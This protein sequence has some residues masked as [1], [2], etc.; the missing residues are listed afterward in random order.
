MVKV[1]I[2]ESLLEPVFLLDKDGLI[3]YA[4]PVACNLLQL[5]EKRIIGKKRFSDF[6]PQYLNGDMAEFLSGVK[7]PTPYKE[8]EFARE[9]EIGRVQ[10]S[11]QKLGDQFLVYTR[12]VTLENR[13]QSKYQKQLEE[14]QC[15]IEEL[16]KAQ[17]ELQKINET[18]EQRVVERTQ[19]LKSLNETMSA[20]LDSLDQGFLIFTEEGDCLPVYSKACEDIFGV[21]PSGQKIWD[22]FRISRD[23]QGK[24]LDWLRVLF[25]NALPFGDLAILGPQNLT[26]LNSRHISLKYFPIWLESRELKSVVVMATDISP[27][28]AAKHE[29]E[30]QKARAQCVLTLIHHPS[31][32]QR[33]SKEANQLIVNLEEELKAPHLNMESAFRTLHTIKGGASSFAF[34]PLVESCH[35]GEEILDSQRQT[36][37]L[38]MQEIR[39]SLEEVRKE[40]ASFDELLY[41]L[42]KNRPISD[43]W[44][45]R[46]SVLDFFQDI[47]IWNFTDQQKDAL[48]AAIASES[49]EK[50]FTPFAEILPMMADRLGKEVHP[51]KIETQD[52]RWIP[53]VYSGFISVIPH[54]IRNAMDHGLE[55][56]E[57]RQSLGKDSQ[58]TIG[59]QVQALSHECL[60]FCIYDD[61]SGINT[62]ALRERLQVK[63]VAEG[64]L[65]D[66]QV[67]QY[68]FESNSSTKQQ[69]SEW[70]GRGVGMNSI[71]EEVLKL[72]GRIWVSSIPQKGTQ[73]Q[74]EIPWIK[75]WKEIESL[76]MSLSLAHSSDEASKVA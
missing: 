66:E 41:L 72:G 33:F 9:D 44:I 56:A 39:S 50:S 21:D 76:W 64:L 74:I 30:E 37:Q 63:G 73:L 32:S 69:V 27:L 29:A 47:A 52:L 15:V 71:R 3:I 20:L 2:F 34:Q 61:G 43:Q 65:T 4:N 7:D 1:E 67:H 62:K 12:D 51:L 16:E 22:M 49:V 25:S 6:W 31:E 19:A 55:T 53:E 46:V 13:L 17:V 40:L 57:V 23:K 24:F 60:R 14:K 42:H 26:N 45:Q 48:L 5:P 11:M 38:S 54:A 35:R 28:V 75:T 59:V 58:G 8:I 68:I 18:L 70:S 36:G 10:I